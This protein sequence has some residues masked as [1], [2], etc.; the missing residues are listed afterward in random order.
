VRGGDWNASPL[1]LAVF[2]GN[3]ALTRFLLEHGASWREEHGHR[4]NVCGTLSWASCNEP[5]VGGDWAGCARALL[6]HGMPQATFDPENPE[7]VLIA[8]RRKRFSDQ[9]TDVLLG[10]GDPP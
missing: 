4:D 8:G 7:W 10:V 3:V 6:E 9:V 1:N 5:I 2:R